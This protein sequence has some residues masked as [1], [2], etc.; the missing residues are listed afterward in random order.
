MKAPVDDNVARGLNQITTIGEELGWDRWSRMFG[1][2]QRMESG[3]YEIDLG[4]LPAHLASGY[5]QSQQW[6]V[7]TL[8]LMA[9]AGLIRTRTVEPPRRRPDEDDAEFSARQEDFYENARTRIAVE[10]LDGAATDQDLWTKAIE[11]QRA[12]VASEQR[13]SL[14]RMREV[15]RGGRCVSELIAS[16]YLVHWGRR[17]APDRGQLPGLPVMPRDRAGRRARGCDVPGRARAAAERHR[18]AGPSRGSAGEGARR[19]SLAEPHLAG[20]ERSR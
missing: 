2:A 9:W 20:R 16:H 17:H 7:R 15:L 4:S 14:Q 13:T 18:V 6:N 19:Q 3:T 1:S 12:A 11:A 10:L 8:N 5:G